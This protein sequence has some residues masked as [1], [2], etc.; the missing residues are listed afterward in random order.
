MQHAWALNISR[1]VDVQLLETSF[2]KHAFPDLW[3]CLEDG[4]CDKCHETRICLESGNCD[5]YHELSPSLEGG[6]CDWYHEIGVG[7]NCNT[8]ERS[9]LREWW[10]RD[11]NHACP[12][13]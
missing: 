8:H 10:I 1:M 11:P 7:N 5:L 3:V 9:M 6:W 13:I 2:R 4:Q 12:V